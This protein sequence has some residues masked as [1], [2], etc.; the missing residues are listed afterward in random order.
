MEDLRQSI[1][2]ILPTLIPPTLEQVVDHL[3]NS[4]GVETVD[5]LKY[6]Q[7]EDLSMLKAIQAC[8]LIAS[9][10][11]GS[12]KSQ[13]SI[14]SDNVSTAMITQTTN[15]E[16]ASSSLHELQVN[17]NAMWAND[18]EFP[19]AKFSKRDLLTFLEK[20][21]RPNPP[22]RR[23]MVRILVDEISKV[24]KKKGKKALTT[25]AHK[26]VKQ[27]PKS[28]QDEINGTIVGT[29]FD[30]L[31]KQL[32]L[33]FDNVN[34]K[35]NGQSMK[36]KKDDV[37][38]DDEDLSAAKTSQKDAKHDKHGCINYMPIDYP[39]GETKVSQR[40]K[41]TI[42]KQKHLFGVSDEVGEL[43][44]TTYFTQRI[45]IIEKNLSIS[46]LQVEWPY[47]FERHG[48][49]V[50]FKE[51]TGIDIQEK[52]N[53]VYETQGKKNLQWMKEQQNKHMKI[54]VNELL[55]AKSTMGNN[56]PEVAA[57]ICAV[58]SHL[59]EK[60]ASLYRLVEVCG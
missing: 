35:S 36:R 45:D 2:A 42:L 32:Q 38:A 3:A 47:L 4:I 8:K 12:S 28:F 41:K 56:S 7:L 1:Q 43:M 31:L 21:M 20:G 16:C 25:I 10:T 23:E 52:L 37:M 19:W 29:G 57:M 60:E 54:I 34:R 24:C 13:T 51:L 6:V 9:W 40:N 44:Q 14:K 39:D 33:R 26:I 15:I 17:V 11:Q 58:L 49:F 53:N 18:Y 46:K 5:D 48:M 22:A 27:Y 30:S 55:E 50:H 59:N